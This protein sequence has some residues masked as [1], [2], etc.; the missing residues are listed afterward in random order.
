M[1]LSAIV[2]LLFFPFFASAGSAFQVRELSRDEAIKLAEAAIARNGCSDLSPIKDRPKLSADQPKVDF[3]FLMQHDLD[4]HAMHARE[5]QVNGKPAWIIGFWV[6]HRY[7][8]MRTDSRDR[9][10]LMDK[11]GSNLRLEN[12]KN[13]I[14]RILK[15]NR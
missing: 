11:N 4:C 2:W 13:R 9:L 5:A 1:K 7:P 6:S 14:K 12:R 3:K 10:V 8:E 15:D